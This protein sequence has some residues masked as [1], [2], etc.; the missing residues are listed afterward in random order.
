[1]GAT[2]N[3]VG[4]VCPTH[5]LEPAAEGRPRCH[6]SQAFGVDGDVD[7][8]V[9][10]DLRLLGEVDAAFGDPQAV[11]LFL[12][13]C[14]DAQRTRSPSGHCTTV[15]AVLSRLTT[16][17]LTMMS[18]DVT[19]DD[20]PWRNSALVTPNVIDAVFGVGVRTSYSTTTRPDQA[21]ARLRRLVTGESV[22]VS[23]SLPAI[24]I[25]TMFG[26][27]FPVTPVTLQSALNTG[28][29]VDRGD[30]DPRGTPLRRTP[31][32]RGERSVPGARLLLAGRR[33]PVKTAQGRRRV[34]AHGARS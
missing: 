14:P 5:E 3:D 30:A 1:M 17:R 20:P 11:S 8:A 13:I 2:E 32:A 7:A 10:A 29:A 12:A 6:R 23:L 24:R 28:D 21:S 33:E 18:C 9:G 26:G 15:P 31:R 16:S 4:S 34:T 27:R 19:V 25:S 22:K